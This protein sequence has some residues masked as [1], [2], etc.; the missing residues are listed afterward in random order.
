[1]SDN[2]TKEPNA[3]KPDRTRGYSALAMMV[4]AVSFAVG[5]LLVHKTGR[6]TNPFHYN[7]TILTAQSIFLILFLSL[8]KKK[9]FD[10]SFTAIM[11]AN[12]IDRKDFS[13]KSELKRLQTHLTHFR[14]ATRSTDGVTTRLAT[15]SP[16]QARYWVRIS[17]IWAIVGSL[18]YA[19]LTWASSIVETAVATTVYELWPLALVYGKARHD[20]TDA[21]YL[22]PSSDKMYRH[23]LS[24]QHI[25]LS[26]FAGIGIAFLLESQR[27]E[28]GSASS[29]LLSLQ[30]LN[31][32]ALA[33]IAGLLSA[34]NVL[35]TLAYGK[36]LY[37]QLVDE[38]IAPK[39]RQAKSIDKRGPNDRRLLLW[40]TLLGVIVARI[41]TVPIT[42]FIGLVFSREG[43]S[44]SLS[45]ASGAAALG[46]AFGVGVILIRTG[47]IV[48]PGPGINALIFLSP[49]IA[50]GLLMSVGITLPRF[51]LFVVGAILIISINIIIQ[52]RPD[53]ERD[54]SQFG[55]DP[56]PGT[57]LGFGGFIL[58]IWA[59]G[60][61]VYTRDEFMPQFWLDWEIGEYWGLMALSA[62][63]FALILGFRLARLT[64][65][66]MNEDG[67]MFSLYHDAQY[68]VA[69]GVVPHS[70]SRSLLD[71]DTARPQEML[72]VYNAVKNDLKGSYDAALSDED[73][74][75]LI[76]I[77]KQLDSVTHSKQQ[78]RDIAE[79]LSLLAFAAVTI[80]LGLLARP[81]GLDLEDPSW[82]G[83]LSEVFILLFIST[84]AFLCFNL[85]DIRRER[86]TP[87]MVS[88]GQSASNSSMFF[89][90]KANLKWRN[91]MAVGICFMMIAIF[92]VLLF[93]KWLLMS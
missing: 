9:F 42:L 91:T 4:A 20:Q 93:E 66:I 34:I 24:I 11:D 73:K 64:T 90:Y 39:E 75:L 32:I 58:S 71:L 79:I 80:A 8:T 87:L 68:L 18:D 40:L 52:I 25:F 28:G 53:E 23:S 26:V 61:F 6:E 84:V 12:G 65:R 88:V 78:G 57:R 44:I 45:S 49:P 7:I 76:S 50:L 83:F 72:R 56:L 38:R 67:I 19:F 51:D 37:Y 48:A 86:E 43:Q 1:M 21:R 2:E 29:N 35:A 33:L 30:S 41:A 82:T 54:Y 27:S 13:P 70:I 16:R 31:G 47:N 92:C 5:P 60:T 10:Q 22:N 89:R 36:I 46:I 17:L 62:T 3:G 63:V 85:F 55:K 15:A 59:F 77:R 81:G 69:K 74:T 14:R